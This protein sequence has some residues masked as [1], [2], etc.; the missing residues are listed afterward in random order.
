[1]LIIVT[2]LDMITRSVDNKSSFWPSNWQNEEEGGKEHCLFNPFSAQDFLC[3][4]LLE[5]LLSCLIFFVF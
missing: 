5:A 4:C 2:D 1:M 3:S